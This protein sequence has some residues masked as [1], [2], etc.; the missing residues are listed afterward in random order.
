MPHMEEDIHSFHMTP[1][2]QSFI[3]EIV[4]FLAESHPKWPFPSIGCLLI[5]E[6]PEHIAYP[7]P[8]TSCSCGMCTMTSSAA[9]IN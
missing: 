1:N 5:L 7:P 2:T 3:S 4:L 6:V 8:T 9:L